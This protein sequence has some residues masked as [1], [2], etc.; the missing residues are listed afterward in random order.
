MSVMII[1]LLVQ[2]QFHFI[3]VVTLQALFLSD[4]A[5]MVMSN[6]SLSKSVFFSTFILLFIQLCDWKNF[7]NLSGL[8][9]R[10]SHQLT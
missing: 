1:L 6:E 3:T 9:S 7:L 8:L 5:N 2:I 4:A 10:C